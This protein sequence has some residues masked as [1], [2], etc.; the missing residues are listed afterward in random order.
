MCPNVFNLMFYAYTSLE[1]FYFHFRNAHGI[2]R[3]LDVNKKA[4]DVFSNTL[5]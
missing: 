1:A 2:L 3:T 4:E 5:P